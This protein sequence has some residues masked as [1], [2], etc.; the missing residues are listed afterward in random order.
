[1]IHGGKHLRVY[2]KFFEID[3]HNP[4]RCE[5]TGTT[6]NVEVTHID[7]SGMGGRDSAHVIE[8]LMCLHKKIHQEMGDI[9]EYKEGLRECHASFMKKRT[10]MYELNP[11]HAIMWKVYALYDKI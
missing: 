10:P 5:L 11:K 6:K 1:M 4:R 7:A 2:D 9:E 8:N 3:K